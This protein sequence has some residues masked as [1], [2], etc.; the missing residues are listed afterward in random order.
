VDW[1]ASGR[2]ANNRLSHIY[3]FYNYKAVIPR[4]HILCFQITWQKL[5]DGRKY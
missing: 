3:M 1:P 5:M 4:D 2:P